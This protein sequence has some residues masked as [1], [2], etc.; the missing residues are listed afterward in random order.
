MDHESPWWT[1]VVELVSGVALVTTLICMKK[2]INT[3]SIVLINISSHVLFQTMH[4][5]PVFQTD[6]SF[7]LEPELMS[8]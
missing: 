1:T 7:Y 4:H 6:D 5:S 2:K 3:F 8:L